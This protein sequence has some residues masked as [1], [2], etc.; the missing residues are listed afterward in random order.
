MSKK[1]LWKPAN[2]E[3]GLTKYIGFLKASGLYQFT[4]YE[5]LHQWSVDEKDFFWKSIFVMNI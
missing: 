5:K 4:N 2:I 3:S 1:P